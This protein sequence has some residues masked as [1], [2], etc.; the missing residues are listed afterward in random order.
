MSVYF[1]TG[2]LGGGKT[3]AAVD[4]IREYLTAG[5][6]VATNLDLN[7]E[8]LM[9]SGSRAVVTRV[10]DKPRIEDLIALGKGCDDGKHTESKFGLL[11]LDECLTWLNSRTWN[12]KSRLAVLDWFLHARKMR[13]DIIFIMQNVDACDAQLRD[14]LCEHFVQCRRLDRLRLFKVIKLPRIHHANVY[15]G[16]NS[17]TGMY[18]ERWVYRGTDLFEAYD[19]EQVFH[20]GVEFLA[21]GATDMRAS[22]TQLSAWH[23][24]G[25][26]EKPDE[27]Q[28]RSFPLTWKLVLL[29]LLM[30]WAAFDDNWFKVAFRERHLAK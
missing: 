20:D 7:L 13:W 26:Y 21:S 9:P 8:H 24:K 16:T 3:L 29:P 14:S 1:V 15:Y 2:R 17:T 10:P 28:R 25:R 4:K 11:V 22:Y 12:D 19:T 18:V 6:R 27:V 30:M 23:L 5:R